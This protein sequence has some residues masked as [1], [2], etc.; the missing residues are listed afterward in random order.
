MPKRSYDAT[1]IHTGER[2]VSIHFANEGYVYADLNS[3]FKD[4]EKVTVEIKSRRKP[5]SLAQNDFYWG[6]FLQYQIDCFAEYWGEKYDKKQVHDWNKQN[7]FGETK[8]IEKTGEIIRV[9]GSSS[10]QSTI[11]FEEKLEKIRQWFML[12]FEWQIPLPNEVLK[13]NI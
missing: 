12:N 3:A 4:Q 9:P 6:Y 2:D 5:R 11:E 7:F 13:L 8:V 1:I 10:N